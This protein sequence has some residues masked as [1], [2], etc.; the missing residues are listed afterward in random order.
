MNN[1]KRG[2][3]L[4]RT[5]DILNYM[6]LTSDTH[7]E[8]EQTVEGIE[9]KVIANSNNDKEW[10]LEHKDEKW[11]GWANYRRFLVPLN[12]Y[13]PIQ[14]ETPVYRVYCED[15]SRAIFESDNEEEVI[16]GFEEMKSSKGWSALI[17]EEVISFIE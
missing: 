12:K 13:V 1:L 4:I 10:L 2:K 17:K 8:A 14:K 3:L 5:E 9:I 15:G 7:I 6:G 16:K 11:Y